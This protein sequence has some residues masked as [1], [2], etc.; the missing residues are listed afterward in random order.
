[1]D[2]T[3]NKEPDEVLTEIKGRNKKWSYILI[4]VY[5]ICDFIV[6]LVYSIL[7]MESDWAKEH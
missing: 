5:F 3:E 6:L 1:M 2:K 4:A 7:I